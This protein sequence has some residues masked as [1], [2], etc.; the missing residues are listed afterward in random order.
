MKRNTLLWIAQSLVAA[1][2]AWAAFMKLFQPVSALW[3]WAGEVPLAFVKLTGVID[4]LG[5]AG[6]MVPTFTRIAA[7]GVTALMVCASVFHMVRGEISSIWINIV[8]AI[9]SIFIILGRSKNE[10]HTAL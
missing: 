10:K 6:L 8:L 5:A 7:M 1:T 3:P 9:I 4:L 2:L